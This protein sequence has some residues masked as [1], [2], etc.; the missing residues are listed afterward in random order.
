MQSLHRPWAVPFP[1]TRDA[2]KNPPSHSV[3]HL[4]SKGGRKKSRPEK[5][6]LL[7]PFIR[8]LY[9]ATLRP[10]LH[11]RFMR[12]LLKRFNYFI[13]R[14]LGLELIVHNAF[15]RQRFIPDRA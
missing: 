7:I 8:S 3:C 13:I 14:A 4:L 5:S 9:M 2:S 12:N 15:A 11:N 10:I 6:V 1:L